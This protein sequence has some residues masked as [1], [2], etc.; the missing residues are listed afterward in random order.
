MNAFREFVGITGYLGFV[1]LL[2][3]C[4]VAGFTGGEITDGEMDAIIKVFGPIVVVYLILLKVLAP[5]EPK[6]RRRR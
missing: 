5:D 3:T 6:K 4:I 1:A 2:A